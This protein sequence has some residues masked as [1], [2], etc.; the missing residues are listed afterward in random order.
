MLGD[1]GLEVKSPNSQGARYHEKHAPPQTQYLEWKRSLLGEHLFNKPTRKGI[2]THKESGKLFPFVEIKTLTIPELLEWHHKFYP[3]G[4]GRKRFDNIDP[5]DVNLLGLTIWYEDD[6]CL[7]ISGATKKGIECRF[8]IDTQYP[9]SYERQ[10]Q[11]LERFGYHPKVCIRKTGYGGVIRLL[12]YESIEFLN[13]TQS[14]AHPD[15]LYKWNIPK[16]PIER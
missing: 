11:I 1:G 9:T 6:G 7:C 3:V 13:I 5:N 4:R 16:S 10:V 15:L 12:K 14:Y 8:A 2:R